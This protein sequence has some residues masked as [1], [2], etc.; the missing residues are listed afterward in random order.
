MK[1]PHI[2]MIQSVIDKFVEQRRETIKELLNFGLQ[3]EDQREFISQ[4]NILQKLEEAIV[5]ER[6]L[7]GPGKATFS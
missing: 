7:A 6:K 4:Q 5:H 1:N 3:E 2:E